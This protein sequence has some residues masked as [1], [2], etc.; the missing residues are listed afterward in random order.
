M[1]AALACPPETPN[2][3]IF[4]LQR[5]LLQIVVYCKALRHHMLKVLDIS[6]M[7]E[8]NPAMTVFSFA[9]STCARNQ[10]LD[11]FLDSSSVT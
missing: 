9:D 3:I 7:A 5:K 1:L 6:G 10:N 11:N 8:C 4:N 2:F